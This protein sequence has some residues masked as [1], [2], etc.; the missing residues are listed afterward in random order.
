MAEVET[1]SQKRAA[2]AT[3][4]PLSAEVKGKILQF[5]F[6]ML[7][8]G[9]RESTIVTRTNLIKM[10]VRKGANLYDPETVKTVLA[11]QKTWSEGYKVSLVNIYSCF[12]RMEGLT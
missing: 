10:L 3:A 6:W 11:R 4:K 2:G 8:E 5:S 12:L 7:N 9:Y 1:R